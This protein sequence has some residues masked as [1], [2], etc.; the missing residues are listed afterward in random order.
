MRLISATVLNYRSI[1]SAYKIPIE[2]NTVLIGPNNEGKSN[3]LNAL[4]IAMRELQSISRFR[5]VGP[6][7]PAIH[8]PAESYRVRYRS[9]SGYQ[10][11]RDYPI[12]H[13]AKHPD[14]K[15][16]IT[17]EFELSPDELGALRQA[18]QSKLSGTLALKVSLGNAGT[19]ITVA[20]QGPGARV[21]TQK[22]YEIALFISN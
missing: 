1:T 7:R 14:G 18:I 13:Q 15:S 12:Q 21:L 22:R 9:A 6:S 19:E 5:P 3:I 11:D 20:K 4:V 16:E 10:W 2:Q 17:L 8:R